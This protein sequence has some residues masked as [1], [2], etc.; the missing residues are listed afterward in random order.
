M[1]ISYSLFFKHKVIEYSLSTFSKEPDM[2]F[3]QGWICI[4]SFSP[5]PERQVQNIHAVKCFG[6]LFEINSVHYKCS[7]DNIYE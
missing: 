2:L 3:S 7:A 6:V 4:L 1:T 5:K